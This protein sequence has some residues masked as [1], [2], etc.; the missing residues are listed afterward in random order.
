MT[1]TETEPVD[2]PIFRHIAQL[3][4]LAMAVVKRGISSSNSRSDQRV[5]PAMPLTV[6]PAEREGEG[7][8][9]T[10]L[11]RFGEENRLT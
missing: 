3:S 1:T 7:Q 10:D 2:Q 6:Q 5:T 9:A 4:G 8:Q 11:G